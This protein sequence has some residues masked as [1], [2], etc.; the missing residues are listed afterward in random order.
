MKNEFS[1][2]QYYINNILH[3]FFDV[4]VTAYIDNIL[5][6]SNFLLEYQKH[7]QL[8]FKQLQEINLQCDIQKYKFHASKMTYFSLIMF[9]K[10]IK[11]NS[12]KVETIIN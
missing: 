10:E 1:M 4:F 5:I 6:Y 2:F 7:V 3:E 9:Q 8:I 12:I 11:M